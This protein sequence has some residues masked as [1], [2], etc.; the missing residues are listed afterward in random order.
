MRPNRIDAQRNREEILRVAGEAFAQGSDVVPLEEIARRAQLGR[1]TIYRHFPDRQALGLA[2]AAQRLKTL[3]RTVKEENERPFGELLAMVLSLQLS[4]RPLVRFFQDLPVRYQRQY[5]DAVVTLL[6]PAFR[7]AQAD[8]RLR[9]DVEPTDL[10]LV[11]DMVETAIATAATRAHRGD[12]AQRIITV[13]LDGFL[14]AR[15]DSAT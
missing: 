7:R 14:M 8:G 2:V 9:D 12:P 5:A 13:I 15:K 6:T 10:L 11:F 4:W 1:A 3:R